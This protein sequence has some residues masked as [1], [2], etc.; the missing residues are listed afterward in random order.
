[1]T[2]KPEQAMNESRLRDEALIFLGSATCFF[3]QRNL[4][5]KWVNQSW[6][7]WFALSRKKTKETKAGTKQ[8]RIG[9][10]RIRKKAFAKASVD[11][12]IASPLP[13]Y[14]ESMMKMDSS[15]NPCSGLKKR[16]RERSMSES[17]FWRWDEREGE[18]SHTKMG[19]QTLLFFMVKQS[20][21]SKGLT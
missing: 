6:R 5:L 3:M 8:A 10:M 4:F 14:G 11:E 7:S 9:F 21:I 19:N 2:Q 20:L 16:E 17:E 18:F 1:M 13:L 12:A 15:A